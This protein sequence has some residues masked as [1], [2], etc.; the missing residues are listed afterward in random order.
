M[1]LDLGAKNATPVGVVSLWVLSPN[2][3]KPFEP[4][5]HAELFDLATTLNQALLP[6]SLGFSS[7]SAVRAVPN[8]IDQP[9]R[10]AKASG[11]M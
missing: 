4:G 3:R 8:V 9:T 10:R 7:A 1:I 2:L 11:S 5:R 6:L